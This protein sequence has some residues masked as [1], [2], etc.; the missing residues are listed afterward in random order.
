VHLELR[1]VEHPEVA[2]EALDAHAGAGV[3]DHRVEEI[4]RVVDVALR[5]GGAFPAELVRE[6]RE[7][8]LEVRRQLPRVVPA[9]AAPD[10]VAL[11]EQDAL[12]RR[13]EKEEGGR[14][15]RDART[16]DERVDDRVRAERL[17]RPV[18]RALR[19]PRRPVGRVGVRDRGPR[20]LS[21]R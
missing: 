13:A 18:R 10:A 8:A 4:L 7:R 19:E 5:L 6:V 21:Q 9:C 2:G 15:P 3:S 14:D 1:A 16:D 20:S 11:D 17:G 12:P